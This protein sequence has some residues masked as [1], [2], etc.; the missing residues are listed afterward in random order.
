MKKYNKDVMK[1]VRQHLGYDE[2]DTSMDEVIMKLP[3]EEVFERYCLWN[4]LIG[5][6]YQ[7]LLDA[8][9]SIYDVSLIKR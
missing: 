4:G 9:E 2:N 3:K 6:W 1:A 7:C 5:G 8:V